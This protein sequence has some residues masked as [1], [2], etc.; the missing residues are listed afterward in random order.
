MKLEKYHYCY[1]FVGFLF[2]GIAS[3]NVFSDGMF[4]DG[5]TYAAIS[6]NMAE[7]LGSFW[8][9]HY[10]NTLFNKFYEHPPLAFGLQSLWFQLFGDSIF[11]ERIYS[12]FT[13]IIAGYLIVLIWENFTGNKKHGW[14][15][16]FFWVIINDIPWAAANNMLEN[17]MSIFVCL[18]VLFYLN[19]FRNKR[20]L[21]IILSGVSLF[22]G[23]LTKGVFCLYIWSVPFFIWLF[24]REK[25]FLQMV[26]DT[27]ILVLCTIIPVALIYILIP[28]AQNNMLYYFNNQ[29]FGSIQNVKTVDTRFAIIEKFFGNIIIPLIIGIIVIIISQKHK[30]QKHIFKENL[31]ESLILFAI[32]LSGVLPIMISMK[33]SSFYILTVYPFFAIGLAYYLYPI[34]KLVVEK[35]SVIIKRKFKIFKVITIGIIIISIGLSFGQISRIGRDKE[36]VYD[37]KMVIDVVG[38]NNIINICPNMFSNWSLHAYFSRYGNVSLDKNQKNIFKYYLS[39]GNCSKGYLNKNYDLIPIKMKKYKLYKLK[40]KR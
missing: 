38:T 18:S 30:I 27:I 9:P 8:T 19:S 39:S 10:T 34:I 1:L 31:K 22:L 12:I 37:S 35:N 36:M 16:L 24:K 40:K 6:K 28:A 3:V 14:I 29:V 11:I 25:N 4:L 20:F 13:F 17:S 32:V 7:G 2:L 33:Q 5:A 15:P 23:F 26:T 21:W